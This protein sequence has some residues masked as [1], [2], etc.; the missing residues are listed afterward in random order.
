[1]I[2]SPRWLVPLFCCAAL[3]A[4]CSSNNSGSTTGSSVTSSAGSSSAVP[5]SDG[6]STLADGSFYSSAPCPNPLVQG[7]PSIDLGPEFDCGY[8]TVPENRSDPQTKSI[9]LAVAR[10]KATDPNPEPDP[11]IYLA[12]GPGGTGLAG[13]VARV[14]DGWNSNRDVIFLDQRGTLKS[15]PLLSCPEIDEFQQ[16]SVTMSLMAPSTEAIDVAATKACFDRLTAAGW[17]L[18]SYN[19]PEI[20]ADV[21]DLRLAMGID[22][23]NVYGVSYGTDLALQTLRDHP[24]GIRSLVLDSVV[25]PQGNLFQDFWDQAASGYRALFDACKAQA[26]CAA[27]YPDLEG[28][29]VSLV[30]SLAAQPRTVTVPDSRNNDQPIDVVIDGYTLANLLVVLSLAPGSYAAAPAMIHNL[31]TGDGS[32]AA[33]AIL[34]GRPTTGVTGYGETFGVFCSEQAPFT[35]QSKVLA[36]G[37]SA[38][39]QFPASVLELTPQIPRSFADCAAWNIEAADAAVH[40]PA[41]S[42]VPILILSGTFDAITA[43]SWA[44]TVVGDLPSSN[45]VSFPG[46]AHDV[47]LWEP[48]CAVSVMHSFLDQPTGYDTSCV[49]ALQIPPFT[50]S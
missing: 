47:M 28:E 20:S 11:L 39:P 24:E 31:A 46:A 49:D 29:F 41:K 4:A 37:Q 33:T 42:D 7:A 40:D 44:D 48:S 50:T 2:K 25:P 13:A 12:G 16:Q 34:G 21:A 10:V 32:Q 14:K 43:K 18:D 8:L 45:I 35:D 5:S 22:E 15:E 27:A 36:A 23:W 17:E 1:M 19:T 9:R 6:T 30:N 3:L 26:G 38:L